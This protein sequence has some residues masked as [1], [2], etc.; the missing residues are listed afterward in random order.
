MKVHKHKG[1]LPIL[2]SERI[3]QSEAAFFIEF[4]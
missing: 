4:Y 2:V 1:T 3:K